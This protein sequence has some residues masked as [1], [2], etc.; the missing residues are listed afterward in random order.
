MAARLAGWLWDAPPPPREPISFRSAA[1]VL[2]ACRDIANLTPRTVETELNSTG[3]DPVVLANPD[4]VVPTANFQYRWTRV[5][6]IALHPNFP[7][8]GQSHRLSQNVG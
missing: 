3:D 1:Q 7:N 5:P 6:K 8:C 4:A 2:G